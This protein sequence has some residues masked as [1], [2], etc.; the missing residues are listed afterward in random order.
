MVSIV[1]PI[2]NGEEFVRRCIDSAERQTIDKEIICIDDGSVDGTLRILRDY[3]KKYSN[4]II[5]QENHTGSG[6]ARNKGILQAKG[7]FIAFLDAD[8]FYIEENA[9][10]EM[11]EA[12][13]RNGV[14]ICASFRRWIIDGTEEK[15]VL[16]KNEDAIY[17]SNGLMVRFID[18]QND[19]CF[20][21]FIYKREFLINNK[22]FFPNLLRYQDPPFLLKCLDKAGLFF[23]V[24][25]YLYCYCYGHQCPIIE[26][27]KVEDILD[28]I[29]D[30]IEFSIEKKYK[31]LINTLIDRIENLYYMDIMANTN[32]IILEKLIKIN[33]LLKKN[34]IGELKI[35]KEICTYPII[36]RELNELKDVIVVS[37]GLEF[38]K[39]K[40]QWEDILGKDKRI[41]IYGL[42]K[43]GELLYEKMNNIGMKIVGLVDKNRQSMNGIK[44]F[45]D[46]TQLPSYDILIVSIIKYSI[47]NQL[48][49]VSFSKEKVLYLTDIMWKLKERRKDE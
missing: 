14:D 36:K 11:V 45:Q 33:S 3:E 43:Y 6:K 44:V 7:E 15:Q 41:C 24:P 16:F 37:K 48:K 39:E 35:L 23:V 18:Y 21:S 13:E 17:E 27:R 30:S 40:S 9:L 10:E 1:I 49:D 26:S 5:L 34:D 38:L 28:G 42:G 47:A 4:I 31:V 2:Y 12:A 22:L 8:D 29:Y 32:P 25:K 20:Q 19:F 46:I